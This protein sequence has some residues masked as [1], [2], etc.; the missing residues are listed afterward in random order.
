MNPNQDTP[1]GFSRY[2]MTQEEKGRVWKKLE[3]TMGHVTPP[4][5]AEL[6][7]KKKQPLKR[8]TK[9]VSHLLF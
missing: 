2:T 1:Q 5:P 4:V 7:Q 8:L 9:A 6:P 3:S